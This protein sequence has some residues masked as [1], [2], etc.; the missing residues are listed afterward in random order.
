MFRVSL[1]SA[2][3]ILSHRVEQLHDTLTMIGC[4]IPEMNADEE[5]LVNRALETL[6]LPKLPKYVAPEQPH[7]AD[8]S[9]NGQRVP[10]DA[11]TEAQSALGL[12]DQLMLLDSA[13]IP[14]NDLEVMADVHTQ[15]LPPTDQFNLELW[16]NCSPEWP[17]LHID[18]NLGPELLVEPD[19]IG[20][21]S[22][23]APVARDAEAWNLT[24]ALHNG[25]D[26]SPEDEEES[27]LVKQLSER[28]GSLRLAPDGKL[29]YFGTASN[30]HL[31]DSKRYRDELSNIRSTRHN[32]KRLLKN[33]EVD[34]F[35]EPAFEDHLLELFFT[36]HNSCYPIVDKDM[37]YAARK[38][39][40]N[41]DDHNSYYSEVLTN[42]M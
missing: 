3:E 7:H 32:G 31:L 42:A 1:R 23:F 5:N 16:D 38:A 39:W 20:N 29:R 8:A 35:V 21:A 30:V 28:L 15:T 13:I 34:Q 17:W 22:L 9:Q 19:L 24:H 27:D 41:G 14:S 37:Y 11:D 12:Q 36:W 10:A 25:S 18:G 26:M 2:V 33:A 4:S 40:L 6:G